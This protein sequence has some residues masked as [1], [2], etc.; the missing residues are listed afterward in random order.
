MGS[1]RTYRT[2]R[3]HKRAA[4]Q[5]NLCLHRHNDADVIAQLESKENKQGYIKALIRADI[6]KGGSSEA[7]ARP[8]ES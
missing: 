3:Y 8:A 7:E 1:N 4:K 6:A 5:Y 2:N